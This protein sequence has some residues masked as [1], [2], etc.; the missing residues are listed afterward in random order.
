MFIYCRWAD[1]TMYI[2]TDKKG[3]A[4]V[5]CDHAYT[6]GNYYLLYLLIDHKNVI[7]R[8]LFYTIIY[9]KYIV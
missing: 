7:N 3:N 4:T 8:I 2:S 6:D 1:K 9:L 5:S